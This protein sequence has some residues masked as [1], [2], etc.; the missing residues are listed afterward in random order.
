MAEKEPATYPHTAHL[1]TRFCY[2]FSHSSSSWHISGGNTYTI[3]QHCYTFLDL[4]SSCRSLME[5][6]HRFTASLDMLGPPIF[7]A[8]LWW[9]HR[10]RFL[11]RPMLW[12]H[13]LLSHCLISWHISGRFTKSLVEK[14]AYS[15]F[16]TFLDEGLIN[17]FLIIKGYKDF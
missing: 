14:Q 4:S 6:P 16:F 5:H 10:H 17:I 8:H 7:L 15:L 1:C 12:H 2:T 9:K 13:Y 11:K 3:S